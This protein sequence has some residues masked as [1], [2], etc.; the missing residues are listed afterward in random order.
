VLIVSCT[1]PEI[2][3]QC[4][5][6]VNRPRENVIKVPRACSRA[7]DEPARGDQ[8]ATRFTYQ[9]AQRLFKFQQG[10]SDNCSFIPSSKKMLGK[11]EKL[12]EVFD[13]IDQFLILR[14]PN[15]I[16]C[17]VC[18]INNTI[19]C[20]TRITFNCIMLIGIFEKKTV[21]FSRKTIH[22]QK[23]CRIN[24]KIVQF[25]NKTGWFRGF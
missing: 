3:W 11:L 1:R 15:F 19:H 20:S 17:L 21:W 5:P 9:G 14:P 22:F 2:R 24:Q 25:F 6:L 18:I 8:G 4:H 10:T 12:V 23:K 16:H 7:R 13:K